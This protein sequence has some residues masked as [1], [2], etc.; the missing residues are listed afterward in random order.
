M[1]TIITILLLLVIPVA[2]AQTPEGYRSFSVEDGMSDNQVAAILQDRQGFTWV[3]TSNGLNW[4]DGKN[5]N[6]LDRGNSVLPHNHIRRLA[7]TGSG[8][9]VAAT[10]M[11]IAEL[12]PATGTMQAI[13]IE[14]DAELARWTN[15][16]QQLTVTAMDERIV[17]TLTGVYVYDSNWNRLAALEDS[18]D[19]AQR[20]TRRIY[21]CLN[22]ASFANGDALI[23]STRGYYLYLRKTRSILPLREDKTPVYQ[24]LRNFLKEHER[25]YVFAI[26]GANQLFFI[27]HFRKEEQLHVL[28]PFRGR[29]VQ[30][31]FSYDPSHYIRWDAAFEFPSANRVRVSSARGGIFEFHFDTA[32]L[33]LTHPVT[34][35]LAMV[36]PTVSYEDTAGRNWIGTRNR[37]Y[38]QQQASQ[39]FSVYQPGGSGADS[40]I[41]GI[42]TVVRSGKQYW[43][44]TYSRSGGLMVL[45]EN[46][47]LLKRLHPSNG[48]Q[49]AQYLYRVIPWNRDSLLVSGEKQ[50]Y[51][52]HRTNYGSRP[53]TRPAF[54]SAVQEGWLPLNYFEDSR[55]NLWLSGGRF[56]GLL[57]YD[58][59]RSGVMRFPP[60]QKDGGFPLGNV[61]GFQEDSAGNI[62]MLHLSMGITRWNARTRS[63][64]STITALAGHQEN[65]LDLSGFLTDKQQRHWYF[66]NHSGLFR[67]DDARSE[68]VKVLTLRDGALPDARTLYDG[69]NGLIWIYLRNGVTVYDTRNNT[70]R[71]LAFNQA[72]ENWLPWALQMDTDRE[73]GYFNVGGESS[74]LSIRAHNLPPLEKPSPVYIR[75]VSLMGSGRRLD[76]SRPVRLEPHEKDLTIQFASADYDRPGHHLYEYKLL[77]NGG[78]EAWVAVNDQQQLHL[79]NL[80]HGHYALQLRKREGQEEAVSQVAF[81]EFSVLPR[82]YETWLFRLLVL[83]VAVFLLYVIYRLRIGQYI[84]EKAIRDRISS[85]LHDDLGARITNLSYLGALAAQQGQASD[86][87]NPYLSGFREELQLAAEALDDIVW[88]EKTL[89]ESAGELVTRMR[90]YAADLMETAGVELEFSEGSFHFRQQLNREKRR[91]IFMAYKEL[92]NNLL[93]HSGSPVAVIDVRSADGIFTLTVTDRGRGKP[94]AGEAERGGRNG[95]GNLRSRIEK[96]KGRVRFEN[97]SGQGLSVTIELPFDGYSPKWTRQGK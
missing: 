90:R 17:G 73:S 28:D 84:R 41:G 22:L 50:S 75:G 31:P 29:S 72:S 56:G 71:H 65:W 43:V 6:H 48:H 94:E 34:R 30:W 82:F 3:G 13:T 1:R 20:A 9:L 10:R 68:A 54:L 59:S 91:D 88:N 81:L 63:F 74:I 47:R 86:N 62:W 14:S 18:F 32:T 67:R 49:P 42:N 53:M 12:D 87:R 76:F 40:L 97:R 66:L 27:N 60:G 44:T 38:M 21:F 95:I 37:L 15:D 55:G 58:A 45:D 2:R 19:I 77:H 33:A 70:S 24:L 11:G 89:D 92:L 5:W 80:P 25:G 93:K 46:F 85:D 69:G 51:L 57:R 26:N 4:F 23:A 61:A 78:E 52:Y 8:R 16:V 83:V 79:H 7:L 39:Y 64:D 35:N 36:V 96:W